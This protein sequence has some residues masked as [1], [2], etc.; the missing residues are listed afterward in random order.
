MSRVG[1]FDFSDVARMLDELVDNELERQA[2]AK[3]N[4]KEEKKKDPVF[5]YKPETKPRF[6]LIEDDDY[7]EEDIEYVKSVYIAHPYSDNPALNVEHA[8]VLAANLSKQFPH[9]MFFNPLNAMKHLASAHFSYEDSLKQ[10]LYWLD[11]CDGL[12][13]ANGWR[14]SKGC[15]AE[16]RHALS[17]WMPVWDSVTAFCEAMKF[18]KIA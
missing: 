8:E 17:Q 5:D 3:K 11:R 18:S 15:V 7:D 12:L 4:F 1:Y 10:C 9:I 14:E 2:Q 13:M 16:R 6:E